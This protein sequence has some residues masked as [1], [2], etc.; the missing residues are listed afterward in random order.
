MYTH[1]YMHLST[2]IYYTLRCGAHSWSSHW[3][4][5]DKF[6]LASQSSKICQL[7]PTRPCL[8]TQ[9][10]QLLRSGIQG[11]PLTPKGICIRV[12][13]EMHIHTCKKRRKEKPHT[14]YCWQDSCGCHSSGHCTLRHSC[15][16]M[17][18]SFFEEAIFEVDEIKCV[19][20]H[21]WG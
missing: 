15:L 21:P 18:K 8:K 16:L 4:G 14:Q 11:W 9:G 7:R 10:G 1:M 3:G 20:S 19:R 13:T 12:H 17:Q 2:H 6:L 5:R